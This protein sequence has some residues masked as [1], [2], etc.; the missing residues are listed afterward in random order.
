MVAKAVRILCFSDAGPADGVYVAVRQD[1]MLLPQPLAALPTLARTMTPMPPSVPSAPS[2]PSAPSGPSAPSAPTA[3]APG[4]TS[5]S[6][7]A[8]A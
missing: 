4:A 3:S 7:E 6:A 2:A 8:G 1:Q 5:A